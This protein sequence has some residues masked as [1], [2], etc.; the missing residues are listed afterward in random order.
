MGHISTLL[1]M[2]EGK[3]LSSY[4]THCI[5]LMV[6]DM[7]DVLKNEIGSGGGRRLIRRLSESSI[8][9]VDHTRGRK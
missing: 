1:R 7:R 6:E 5:D 3:S 4:A 2:E 9:Q 8:S